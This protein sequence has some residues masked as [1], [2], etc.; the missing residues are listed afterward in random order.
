MKQEIKVPQMGESITEATIGTILKEEGAAVK[1]SD[2]IVEL[3]TE[4]VSQ[5]LYAPISGIISWKI[6][7]GDHV[8]IGHVLG[9]ID[10]E[11]APKVEKPQEK[12]LLQ[13][14]ASSPLKK[15]EPTY[16]IGEGKR[17]MK[18]AFVEDIKQAKIE[19]NFS[20]TPPVEKE[21]VPV[22]AGRESRKP[23]TKIRQ[24][25][26][27]RLV[28]S[29]H[30]AAMLT[31]FNEVDMSEIMRLRNKYKATFQEE[32][33]TKLGLMS[34]FVK[35]VVEALKAFPHF[36]SY[37]DGEEIV[38]R[39][40]YDIG[41]AI[42]A[43]KGLVVPV[44]RECDILS[45]PEIEKTIANF[46]EKARNNKLSIADLEGGSFTITNGGVY[47][48]MLST[49][50]LN[51][52]QVGILGM[53]KIT[54]RAVVIDKE[55]VIRPVMYLALSYDHRLIDGREAISFLVYIKEIL[56]DPSK[57]IFLNTDEKI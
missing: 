54:E 37:L 28:Q 47:G 9:F 3:E 19:E 55:I 7:V 44:L 50:I 22:I 40:Y 43:E 5:V 23:M 13:E 34:F 48:S 10:S 1:E 57:L 46:A 4:K 24:T 21:Q 38:T 35:A 32:H 52:P 39:H 45:F 29:L 2:E 42:G 36:N 11:Q 8:K 25:I 49:P 30:S 16:A 12:P 27:S 53:H 51:P 18:E 33:G 15:E 31:T 41:I 17:I 26:A 6:K 56:E 20:P 14:P